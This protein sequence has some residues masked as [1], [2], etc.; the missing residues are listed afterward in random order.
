ME[1]LFHLKPPL[2]YAIS[3]VFLFMIGGFTGLTLGALATN[4]Q[5]HDTTF[6]VA[7]FH[8]IIFGGMGFAFFA[9]IHYWY[10]KITDGCIATDGQ[11]LPGVWF[12]EDLIFFISRFLLLDYRECREDISII[13][14]NFKPA[15]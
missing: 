10:P 13:S 3:F 9:A 2:L 11:I 7:H 15:M 12:L 4:V 1:D 14:L 6:I 5:T 8:Y